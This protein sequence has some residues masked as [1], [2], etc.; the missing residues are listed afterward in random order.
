LEEKLV[1]S[2]DFCSYRVSLKEVMEKGKGIPNNPFHP[3]RH[4]AGG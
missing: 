2:Y 3:T 1:K 4:T